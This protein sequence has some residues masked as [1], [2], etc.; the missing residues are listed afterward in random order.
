MSET[1][2]CAEKSKCV[3]IIGAGI[4]GLTAAWQLSR[5]GYQVV[6]LE[7]TLQAGGMLSAFNL[8]SEKIEHIYHH[9]FTSDFDVL[10]LIK[11]IGLSD[12]VNWYTVKDALHAGGRLYSFSTP[13]DLMR[14]SE[15]P[16]R[17][18]L[19]TGL[20]ILKAGRFSQWQNLED[21]TAA[22]WLIKNCGQKSFEKLWK[23]LLQAKFEDDAEKVSAVWIWNK[24]KL[25][26]GSR[27]RNSQLEKFGY[28][29][30]SFSLLTE[31]LI[32]S[33]VTNGGQIRYG[34]TAM[35]LI[36]NDG[37][38]S[39]KYK[40]SC[41][42]EDCSSID[43]DAD[44]VIST[45]SCRQFSNLSIS[46]NLPEEYRNKLRA[47]R[48]KAN[49]CMVLRLKKSLSQYYWT[50]I[51]DDLPFV[52]TVE[53]TNMTGSAQYGGHIVYLT[54]YLEV[55]D[56]VWTQPDSEIYKSFI[57]GLHQIYP[58]FSTND[59][60]DWRLRRS[61]YAQPVVLC[62]YGTYHPESD[63]P[64]EGIKL[65]GMAQVYPEDRGINYAVR[66]GRQTAEAV[67]KYFVAVK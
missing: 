7:S 15:I 51:C 13:L 52:A 29:K 34:H 61:R 28:M 64:D 21:I 35:G 39:K 5:E 31:S 66:L 45:I 14:F 47:V 60:M 19:L 55:T 41:I 6:V 43:L 4:T 46:L 26:G 18:R 8:G 11:E 49:I 20:A 30:G 50:T 23:P 38:T 1:D 48:Y 16:I 36:H 37:K 54:K 65:A 32:K 33:I 67:D 10:N 27:S 2:K 40:V 22:E 56:P 63:T 17:Q 12:L 57:N 59:I 53:H 3:C 42:L 24:F 25:R 62:G 44:A 9:L 58:E